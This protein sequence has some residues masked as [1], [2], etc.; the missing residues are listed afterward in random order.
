MFVNVTNTQPA[1]R[2]Y[3][4]LRSS[5]DRAIYTRPTEDRCSSVNFAAGTPPN[6]N[7]AVASIGTDGAVCYDG[8]G[9]VHDVLLDLF[10]IVS[11]GAR[12]RGWN[13]TRL[14]DTRPFSTHVYPVCRHAIRV[15][16]G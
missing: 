2:G 9:A 11:C 6:P 13:P 3:G 5:D 12:G 4:L 1:G 8:V 7:L 16:R 10:A 15:G 14:L